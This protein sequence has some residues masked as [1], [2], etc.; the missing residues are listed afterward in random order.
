MCSETTTTRRINTIVQRQTSEALG[1][2]SVLLRRVENRNVFSVDLKTVSSGSHLVHCV[3][4]H[5]VC[6]FFLCFFNVLFFIL[7]L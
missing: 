1:P 2:G 5:V 4:G 3:L 7:F 6:L